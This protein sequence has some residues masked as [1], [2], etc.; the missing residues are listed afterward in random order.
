MIL[1]TIL[2]LHF[3]VNKIIFKS[4]PNTLIETFFNV[5]NDVNIPN[6]FFF[7]KT[8]MQP[9]SENMQLKG[10]ENR[11]KNTLQLNS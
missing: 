3:I 11:E 7:G 9:K 5:Q 8:N 2:F 6:F 1:K 4:I 10:I